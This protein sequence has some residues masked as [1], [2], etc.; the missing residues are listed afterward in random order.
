MSHRCYARR[1]DDDV[2]KRSCDFKEKRETGPAKPDIY[3]PDG[4]VIGSRDTA[5]AEEKRDTLEPELPANYNRYP[6]PSAT[7]K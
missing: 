5:A 3:N 6:P 1:G 7:V 2:E 4:I